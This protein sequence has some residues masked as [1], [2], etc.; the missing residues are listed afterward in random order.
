MED[1]SPLVAVTMALGAATAVEQT[2]HKVY[3]S[4]YQGRG[5]LVV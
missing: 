3:E 1:I 5:V 2:K 4:V